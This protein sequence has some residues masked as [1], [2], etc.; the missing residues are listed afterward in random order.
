M[1]LARPD[2][3]DEAWISRDGAGDGARSHLF[4]SK[5][6]AGTAGRIWRHGLIIG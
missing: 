5:R 3:D 6:L 4:Q 1:L 2:R